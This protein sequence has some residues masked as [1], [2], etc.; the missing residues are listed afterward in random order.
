MP[1]TRTTKI[2]RLRYMTEPLPRDVTVVGPITL[3]LHAAIDQEDTNWIVVLKDGVPR[4]RVNEMSR[5]RYPS[6]N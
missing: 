3:T 4:A 2:E 5:R 1:V 6:A